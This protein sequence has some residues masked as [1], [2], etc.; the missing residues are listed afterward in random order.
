MN[1][2]KNNWLPAIFV[3]IFVSALF[4]MNIRNNSKPVDTAINT[5]KLTASDIDYGEGS[6]DTVIDK[7]KIIVPGDYEFN[8]LVVQDA[9]VTSSQR[10]GTAALIL[11]AKKKIYISKNSKIDF[12]AVG[13][14]GVKD[15][16]SQTEKQGANYDYAGGGGTLGGLGGNGNCSA[17]ANEV[18]LNTFNITQAY[19]QAGGA[20]RQVVGLS[21]AGGGYVLLI[22]P[23]IVIDGEILVDGGAGEGSGGGGSG[24]KIVIIGDKVSLSGTVSA[25]GGLGGSSQ[26]QGAGG[27]GGGIV[28]ISQGYKSSGSINIAGGR[29]GQA[30]DLYT[31]CSGQ[32]GRLGDLVLLEKVGPF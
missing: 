14:S 13:Y 21:G 19:G 10:S 1:K 3:I 6:E 4:T 18:D 8:S 24:G 11:R 22:A 12:T 27:G 28:M 16:V 5:L 15:G 26:I 32:N 9:I 2:Y 30:L 29:G 17:R 23:E 31:G 20:G 25:L 7:D